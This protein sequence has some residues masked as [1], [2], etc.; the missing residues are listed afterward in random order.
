MKRLRRQAVEVDFDGG[1]WTS[2]GGLLLLREADQRLDLIRRI[3]Q[4]IPDPRDPVYTVHP[5]TENLT[6]R[7]IGIAAGYEDANDHDR[8]RHDPAVP[9]RLAFPNRT[10]Q[11]R[12]QRQQSD[13]GKKDPTC[14]R[15]P[16]RSKEQLFC[17]LAHSQSKRLI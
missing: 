3:D 6:S 17:S 10:G 16:D 9:Q 4:A 15:K 14:S 8:L 2:D 12:S 13:Q 11:H 7:I 5:Q 1:A